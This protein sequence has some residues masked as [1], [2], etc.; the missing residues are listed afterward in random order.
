MRNIRE[1]AGNLA[2][3]GGLVTAGVSAVD[4][5]RAA[6]ADPRAQEIQTITGELQQKYTIG[7]ECGAVKIFGVDDTVCS[8]H[9]MGEQTP[10]EERKILDVYHGELKEKT[11]EVI[12]NPVIDRRY[13]ID[14]GGLLAGAGMLAAGMATKGMK[15][16]TKNIYAEKGQF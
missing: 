10:E 3:I 2:M 8:N 13:A 15:K 7:E 1:I 6:A 4:I 11:D 9:V 5:F 12:R 16:K 14:S